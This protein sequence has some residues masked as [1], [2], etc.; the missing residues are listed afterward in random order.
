M[1]KK[2]LIIDQLDNKL[3][4]LSALQD[5]ALPSNGWIYSIRTALGMS[6]RQLG[7]LL[8][9]TPQSVKDIEKREKAGTVSI[10]VLKQAARVLNMKFVYGFIPENKTIDKMIEDR[11]TKLASEIVKRTSASMLLEDQQNSEERIEAA[12]KE[13]ALELKN[14]LPRYLWD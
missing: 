3:A 6:L 12:I 11:A 8:N 9:I 10:K 7:N 14:K 5:I 13:T 1:N 2:K 4:K